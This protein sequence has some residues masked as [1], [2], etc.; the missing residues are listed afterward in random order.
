MYVKDVVRVVH[1]DWGAHNHKRAMCIADKIDG[2]WS[3]VKIEEAG[4]ARTLLNRLLHGIADNA[5]L[6]VGFDFPI[7]YPHAYGAKAELTGFLKALPCFGQHEWINFFR[8]A[9][10][11]EE[12]SIHR[13]FYPRSCPTK[14][15]ATR[16]IFTTEL[17]IRWQDMFRECELRTEHRTDASPLFWTLGPK[18]VGTAAMLGWLEIL[19]P[20]VRDQNRCF[21]IWPFEGNLNNLLRERRG[22]IVETYP[23]ECY[24]H[25]GF[26]RN[27]SGK[28][29]Q[30]KRKAC[31]KYFQDWQKRANATFSHEVELD[32]KNGFPARDMRSEEDGEDSFDAVVGACSMI[33]VVE[34]RRAEGNHS[35][36]RLQAHEGWIFGQKP[37]ERRAR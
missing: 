33:D 13:P 28:R 11:Q 8:K 6:L 9:K 19:Q 31:S 27:W 23:G 17:E 7:G 14:G 20:I 37:I 30:Q 22:V 1:C 18:A 10:T 16:E 3:I 2:K 34:G 25:L 29:S 36:Q 12:L 24:N 4:D 32:L 15:F 26:P 35:S 21:G 5:K